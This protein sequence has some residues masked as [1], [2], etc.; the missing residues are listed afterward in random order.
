MYSALIPVKSLAQAKSRLTNHLTPKQR[1]NLMLDMLHHVIHTLHESELF[2]R[3]AVVSADSYV[4][5]QTQKWGAYPYQEEARG[6]N[7]ALTAAA[8]HEIARDVSALLTISADLPLLNTHDLSTM[9][10]LLSTAEVV[11]ASSQDGT[12]TNAI[13]TR[14]PLLVPYVFGPYSYQRYHMEAARRHLHLKTV[15]RLG[16]ALDIDTITDL[17]ELHQYRTN[18][19]IDYS[20]Q[21][22]QLM[23]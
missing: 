20:Y 14:P 8:Q 18:T 23:C 9:V 22:Q 3:V 10:D 16:L 6:H 7:P 12:G 15:K 2:S 19:T 11:L 21:C 1:A 4:L 13:L 17:Q 5:K